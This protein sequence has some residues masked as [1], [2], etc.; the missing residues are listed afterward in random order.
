M[1]RAAIDFGKETAMADATSVRG[2]DGIGLGSSTGR[3]RL[4]AIFTESRST[5]MG[6]LGVLSVMSLWQYSAAYDLVDSMFL[7]A[8]LEVLFA[9]KGIVTSD[10]FMRDLSVSAYEFGWGLGISIVVGGTLGILSGWYKPVE[11][12]LRPIVIALNS[13][14]HLALI[15]L[16]ILLFG[17][18]TLPKVLLVLLSCVVV[19]VMNTAAGVQNVDQQLM[20]MSRSFGA[21][22]RQLIKTVVIPSVVPFFM[23]GVRIC[24][25]KAVV[26][27]AVSEIFGSVAG[28]GNILIKAQSSMNMPVMYASVILLTIIGITLTQSAAALEHYIQRWRA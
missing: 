2:S 20:R 3:Q 6:A 13:V 12:F 4:K 22:D 27:V 18:G 14:P 17:I 1:L 15:P 21:S 11:E 19:M 8:P 24:V 25:G 10:T 16:L 26:S 5:F 28:L 7:P 9:L 23:T